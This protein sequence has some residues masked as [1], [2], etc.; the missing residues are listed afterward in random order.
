MASLKDWIR[1]VADKQTQRALSALLDAVR[2]ELA[3]LKGTSVV[4]ATTLSK[5]T[6]PENVAT[7]AFSFRIAGMPYAKAAVAAGTALG[8]TDT[9]NTGAAA[10]LFFGGFAAQI[11]AAGTITFKS[12]A[13]DQTYTSEAAAEAAARAITPT[14][15][16]VIIGWFV[17][18]AKTGAKW[19]AGTDDLTP[20]SDCASVTFWSAPVANFLTE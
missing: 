3:A 1:G 7:T 2:L 19:T 16:N 15:A 6:T 4:A 5:G 12:V 10:G 13:A 9:I 20:T 11:N 14:A 8:I 17:V 18:G